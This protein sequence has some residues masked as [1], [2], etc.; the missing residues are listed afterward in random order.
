MGHSTGEGGEERKRE[1]RKIVSG[2][3]CF[4]ISIPSF[5]FLLI[6]ADIV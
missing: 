1:E 4:E 3:N 5:I 6:V 2:G